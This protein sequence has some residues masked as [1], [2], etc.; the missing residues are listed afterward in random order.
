MKNRID[1]KR[2]ITLLLISIVPFKIITHFL[3]SIGELKR[4]CV[5]NCGDFTNINSREYERVSANSISNS[6]ELV[7]KEDLWI[8]GLV[9]ICLV[10]ISWFFKIFKPLNTNTAESKLNTKP[11]DELNKEKTTPK[12]FKRDESE[13]ENNS[14]IQ[15][16]LKKLK[17]AGIFLVSLCVL[18]LINFNLNYYDTFSIKFLLGNT[19]GYY[20]PYIIIKIIIFLFNKFKKWPT[21]IKYHLIP[22]ILFLIFYY[23]SNLTY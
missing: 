1:D 22:Y 8:Y 7:F 16:D 9:I 12:N 10:F 18:M 13:E 14:V 17:T 20:I 11:V 23:F 19:I 5:K 6:I 15:N 4:V 21:N 2:K 3:F